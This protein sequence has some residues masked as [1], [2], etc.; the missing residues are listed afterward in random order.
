MLVVA[1]TACFVAA[2][3]SLCLDDTVRAV[4]RALCRCQ[5]RRAPATGQ[6]SHTPTP[7]LLPRDAM[8]PRYMLSSC[9]CLI[10]V[11]PSVRLSQAG[12]VQK[13]LNLI[14]TSEQPEQRQRLFPQFF[15]PIFE[16]LE[17]F[18]QA[19]TSV[20]NFLTGIL[21]PSEGRFLSPYGAR[22]HDFARKILSGIIPRAVPGRTRPAACFTRGIRKND[23]SKCTTS[24]HFRVKTQ[25]RPRGRGTPSPHSL[26]PQFQTTSDASE[27]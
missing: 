22:M 14:R 9:V 1:A 12:V 21:Q 7:A 24:R 17:Q 3:A 4:T 27:T 5:R 25:T 20:T 10:Y 15:P 16:T 19:Y 8:L 6:S 11:C 18:H 26:Q 13:S 23:A 2:A